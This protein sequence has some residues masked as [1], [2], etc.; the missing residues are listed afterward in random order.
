MAP[1]LL[2]RAWVF[3][4]VTFLCFTADPCD[5]DSVTFYRFSDRLIFAGTARLKNVIPPPPSTST[6]SRVNSPI[7]GQSLKG[8]STVKWQQQ[9]GSQNQSPESTQSSPSDSQTLQ[10]PIESQLEGSLQSA[11]PTS[12]PQQSVEQQQSQVTTAN[13]T[14]TQQEMPVYGGEGVLAEEVEEREEVPLENW[15]VREQQRRTRGLYEHLLTVDLEQRIQ[16]R[17]AA[18]RRFAGGASGVAS[19]VAADGIGDQANIYLPRDNNA[20]KRAS[21]AGVAAVQYTEATPLGVIDSQPKL[22][23]KGITGKR[24]LV[25]S[26]NSAYSGTQFDPWI[27]DSA[28]CVGRLYIVQIVNYAIVIY[29]KRGRIVRQ[30]QPLNEFF[31][32]MPANSTRPGDFI[33]KATCVFDATSGRF[34]LAAAWLSGGYRNKWDRFGQTRRNADGSTSGYG[35]VVAAS[36]FLTPMMAW[37]VYFIPSSNDGVKSH[38]DTGPPLRYPGRVYWGATP[39]ITVDRFGVYLSTRQ[40]AMQG[41]LGRF[42]GSNIYAIHKPKLYLRS[43]KRIVRFA[44]PMIN[45][46]SFPVFG[47]EPQSPRVT[48]QYGFRGHD[49]VFFGCIDISFTFPL[50]HTSLALWSL[51]DTSS[52]ML[53]HPTIRL[54]YSVITTPA[55]YDSDY[56]KQKAGPPPYDTPQDVVPPTSTSVAWFK[57][58]VWMAFPSGYSLDPTSVPSV[59]L[60]KLRPFLRLKKKKT[61]PT[62]VKKFG[63]YGVPGQSLLSPVIGFNSK[64]RGILAATLIGSEYFPTAAYL[65][66]NQ[67]GVPDKSIFAVGPGQAPLEVLSG[68]YA[69]FGET[70]SISV[71]TGGN[72]WA[73]LQYVSGKERTNEANWATFMF[74]VVDKK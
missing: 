67:K 9:S 49:T 23:F 51:S 58:H 19:T 33:N 29:N 25:A 66:I 70:Q 11:A 48:S 38:N 30:P 52:L 74:K 53:P 14:E 1:P 36:S 39:R 45:Y 60:V 28:V 47:L 73:T 56:A 13:Q 15:R 22:G 17:E 34:F 63:I 62:L 4:A 21:T 65:R 16:A 41:K 42:V 61:F 37:N 54:R 32:V 59:A 26:V 35:I 10:P 43:S 68:T 18:L 50:P 20:L 69:A 8:P 6:A 64:G 46:N 40:Y 27:P 31:G 57:G 2:T 7:E 24:Q 3:L 71:D 44:I 12:A 5:C 55:Y 72:A